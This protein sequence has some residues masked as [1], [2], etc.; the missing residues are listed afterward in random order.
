MPIEP[1]DF[2]RLLDAATGDDRAMVLLTLNCAL[3]LQECVNLEW[4]DIHGDCLI[5]HRRKKGKFLRIATLW[6]ETLEALKAVKR[7]PSSDRIFIA[8]TGAPITISGAGKRFRKLRTTARLEHVESDMIRDG[9]A[10][11]VAAANIND[12]L[13]NLLMGHRCPGVKDHY[14]KR[15]PKMVQPACDAV[16]AHYFPAKIE[17]T[18][19]PKAE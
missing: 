9:A 5:A 13:F 18:A 4:S 7:H 16:H 1:G 11:A 12:S 15:N 17:G 8:N 2:R 14:A 6:S 10:T 3:H 19:A